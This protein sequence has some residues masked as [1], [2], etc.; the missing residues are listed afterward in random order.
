[1]KYEHF[2]VPF[3]FSSCPSTIKTEHTTGE[4]DERKDQVVCLRES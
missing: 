4:D 2:Q 3:I 1:M